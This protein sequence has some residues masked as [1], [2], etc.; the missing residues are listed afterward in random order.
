MIFKS[1]KR[2]MFLPREEYIINQHVSIEGLDVLLLSFTIDNDKNRMWMIY[3]NEDLLK[4]DYDY[5]HREK[6]TTNRE[7]L[8]YSIENHN[9]YKNFY[10]S[11]MEIQ[12]HTVKFGSSSSGPI[13]NHDMEKLMQ[14]Q[15]FAERG[16][17]FEEWDDVQLESL[18]IAQYEQMEGE[19]T[20]SIDETKEL[21]IVLHIDKR[22]K[23]IPIQ[24][25]I[26]VRFGKQN[27]EGKV[28]YY[29]PIL[30]KENYFYINEIYSYNVYEDILKKVEEID[31]V[32]MREKTIKHLNQA[33]E[34]ICPRDK[35]LAVI[36]Y[37]TEDN[38]QLQFHTK[39]YLE[40][41]PLYLSSG[42][43]IGFIGKSNEIGVNG[44]K[45]RE[46]ILQ[47]IDKDFNGELEIEL[48]SRFYEIPERTVS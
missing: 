8:L 24:Y 35:N 36:R 22:V 19:V 33:M 17:I 4:S 46:C 43:S 13:Y 25:P 10:I 20:P 14:L 47:P 2:Q 9:T 23:E 45:L 12:G 29:D 39:S 41:E 32:E 44:Y 15:H 16:L 40:S 48:F 3:E 38:I 21:D 6:F 5:D 7:K 42:S 31:D 27:N 1:L 34:N 18:V 28:K 11:E 26:K 37:E 30:G